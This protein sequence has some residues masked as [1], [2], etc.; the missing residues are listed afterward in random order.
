MLL[1]RTDLLAGYRRGNAKRAAGIAISADAQFREQFFRLGGEI[2]CRDG[3]GFNLGSQKR[4]S[5]KWATWAPASYH[6]SFTA[7]KLGSDGA[8]RGSG[9]SDSVVCPRMSWASVR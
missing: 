2:K 5:A 9:R 4:A 6:I 1:Q 3:H 8:V 7:R